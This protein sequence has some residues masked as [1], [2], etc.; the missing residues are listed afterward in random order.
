MGLIGLLAGLWSAQAIAEVSRQIA[1][2][3]YATVRES[4]EGRT[5]GMSRAEARGYIRAKSTPVI[6]TEV[7]TALARHSS[8]KESA[9]QAL[10]TQATE[11]VVR[12]VHSDV[13]RQPTRQVVR[14]A[15]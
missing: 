14:R 5:N 10:V 7:E 6:R 11:R 3:S 2:L 12:A 9:R 1:Q 8:L 15:A 4:V 13:L